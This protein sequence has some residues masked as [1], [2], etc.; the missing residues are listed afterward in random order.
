MLI[1]FLALFDTGNLFITGS[2]QTGSKAAGG[3]CACGRAVCSMQNSLPVGK[4]KYFPNDHDFVFA[5]PAGDF[6]AVFGVYP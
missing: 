6:L 2:H 5:I 1:V 3:R 4:S